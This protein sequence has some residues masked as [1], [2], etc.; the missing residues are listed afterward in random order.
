MIRIRVEYN[1]ELQCF[2]AIRF[3]QQFQSRVANPTDMVK[4]SKEKSKERKLRN[5]VEGKEEME[6]FLKN[7]EVEDLWEVK[8]N[9][10]I[11]KYFEEVNTAKQ[12]QILSIR[13]ISEAAARFIDKGDREIIEQIF[14]LVIIFINSEIFTCKF[15][16]NFYSHQKNKIQNHLLEGNTPLENL[17]SAIAKYREDRK[18]NPVIEVEEVSKASRKVFQLLRNDKMVF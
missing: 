5:G 16:S 4:L 12:L 9:A 17:D 2:N 10:I 11:A 14:K 13:G 3:G 7:E 6:E 1:D 18:Q 15:N 8:M